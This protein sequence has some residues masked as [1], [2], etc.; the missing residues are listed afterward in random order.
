MTAEYGA[1]R[2]EWVLANTMQKQQGD[3]RYSASNQAWAKKFDIPKNAS[4]FF[5]NAHPVLL[6]SFIDKVREKPSLLAALEANE[7]KSKE[8]FSQKSEPGK[9]TPIK[10]KNESE[11]N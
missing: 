6:N 3:G 2:T 5:C 8:Q 4:G 9:D 11:V 10:N 7:K 1:E